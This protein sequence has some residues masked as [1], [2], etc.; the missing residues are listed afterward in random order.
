M[1]NLFLI[2][3]LFMSLSSFAQTESMFCLRADYYHFA[4]QKD[5]ENL[6]IA[7]AVDVQMIII[8]DPEHDM[9]TVYKDTI[10]TLFIESMKVRESNTI[11]ALARDETGIGSYLI[12][13]NWNDD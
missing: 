5:M 9:L 7:D 3:S 13:I 11:T 10:Q 1:R 8:F 12:Y 4:D 6:D 2:V